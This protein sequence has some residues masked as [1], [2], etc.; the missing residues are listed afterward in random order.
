MKHDEG[1]GEHKGG[2]NKGNLTTAAPYVVDSSKISLCHQTVTFCISF[3][4]STHLN[5]Q[6]HST[7]TADA[8]IQIRLLREWRY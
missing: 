8:D 3:C 2:R 6:S 5:I 7:S 1:E 4:S